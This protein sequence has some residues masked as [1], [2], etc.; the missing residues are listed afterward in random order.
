M[1]SITKIPLGLNRYRTS[2]HH[3]GYNKQ[4]LHC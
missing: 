3:R 4:C 1:S 2:N